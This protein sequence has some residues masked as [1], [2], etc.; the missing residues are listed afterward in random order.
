M[1]ILIYVQN[2]GIQKNKSKTPIPSLNNNKKNIENRA[3][4]SALQIFFFFRDGEMVQTDISKN[5]KKNYC[6]STVVPPP[7]DLNIY[8]YTR[9]TLCDVAHV[10]PHAVA[11]TQNIH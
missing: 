5:I 4:D 10:L 3:R 6:F 7:Y 9:V 2:N 11:E 8:E 1:N